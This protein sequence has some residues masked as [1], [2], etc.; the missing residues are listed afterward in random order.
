MIDYSK[1]PCCAESTIGESNRQDHETV[2]GL[3]YC[4]TCGALLGT[5]YKGDL[6]GVVKFV[7]H[8]EKLDG[9]AEQRYFDIV[10]LGTEVDRVHGWYDRH[11]RKVTQIG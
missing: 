9:A 7:W 4:K 2:R 8:D 11:S 6:F 10:T 3:F 1:C 5:I